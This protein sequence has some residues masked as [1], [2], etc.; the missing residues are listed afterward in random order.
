MVGV[1]PFQ[2]KFGENRLRWFCHL[3]RR[4]IY[5]IVKKSDKITGS[6]NAKGG[7]T[8]IDM[9]CGKKLY[10]LTEHTALNGVE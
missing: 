3:Q 8:Y 7:K 6:K 10:E 9:G 2:D 5:Q 4:P 1:A